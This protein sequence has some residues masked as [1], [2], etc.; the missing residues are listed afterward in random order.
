MEIPK[1]QK[2]QSPRFLEG[3]GEMGHMMRQKDWSLHPLGM[4]KNWPLAL[5]LAIGNLLRTAFPNFI[6]WGQEY[7][8]FYN[9]AYRPSLGDTGK[10]PTILG[11]KFEDAWPELRETMKPIVDEVWRSGRPTWHENQLV[12]ISRNGGIEDVYWTFSYS[13][14]LDENDK[15]AGIMIICMETTQAVQ[16]LKKLEE[17]ED[18]LKFAINAAEL[19]TWDYNPKTDTFRGNNR[20]KDWFGINA[21]HEIELTS[22]MEAI[23]PDDRNRVKLAIE[24]ALTGVN[25]G[26]YDVAYFIKNK[27]TDERK[28]V[29]ALGRAWTD[30]NNEVYR[31]NGTLQDIT[32][33][34]ISVEKLR[35]ANEAVEKERNRFKNIVQKAPVGIALFK[36]EDII[37]QM[38][39]N[40]LLEI[41]DR[42]GHDFVRKALF[43]ALPE[44]ENG[45]RPLFEEVL[46]KRKTVK[47]TEFKVP[48]HRKGVL[49]DAYFD[50]ILQ[51]LNSGG[52]ESDTME[53]MLVANEVTDH[54]IA[55]N[56]LAENENQFRN[57]VQQSP[58]AMAIF[59]SMDL[60]IEM[61][62]QRML[63][64][65]WQRSWEEVVGK[66][67]LD[68][69]PELKN[70]KYIDLL[71]NVILTGKSAHEKNS[72]ALVVV[73]GENHEFYV[74][75]D[76][77]PLKEVDGSVS[78]IMV[79]VVD[80]T[81]QYLA[82][83]KLMNFSKELESQVNERT[84]LLQK[85]NLELALSV[86]KLEQANA[87]L[88]SFAYV[89]SHDLQEPL[90]KIQMYVSRISDQ[91]G[92]NLA[93]NTQRYFDKITSSAKRMRNLIDDL[94]V[95]S[96]KDT[97]KD[98]FTDV[99]LNLILAQ[100]LENLSERIEETNAL[101]DCE[102]LP[103]IFGVPFQ[104]RQVFTNLIGNS[105]KFAKNEARPEITILSTIASKEEIKK[106]GLIKD[107]TYYKIAFKDK[108]IGFP[109][110]MEEKIFEVFYRLHGKGEFEGT[111]I[112][113]SIVKK[114]IENH[115]GKV[116]AESEMGHGTTF[117]LYLPKK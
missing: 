84:E 86:R 4:P 25:D 85:T 24:R 58:I 60:K 87:E 51:P 81:E 13:I 106:I 107:P 115:N 90:R 52:D 40:A 99:D 95:Y 116:I 110:N 27:I 48:M 49:R 64:H 96:R 83:E 53:I 29:R 89:S 59:R 112:G 28:K 42:D 30:E 62:N 100:V 97:S 57:L 43:D 94:L 45:V 74:D 70:Q 11:Q 9:D 3:G 50:F 14:M 103:V 82:R 80:V 98:E 33:Q 22:A 2:Q 69:F 114:I 46:Q 93:G 38:A 10:H 65:F 67:L 75:Y 91:E 20:L 31:F 23:V 26:K 66:K 61:A 35:R 16:N 1:S 8:C 32:E 56:I 54:V 108:G 19:G 15:K 109:K 117:T 101:I 105:L 76:Y 12:P 37:T 104:L 5:R 41:V 18:Q 72:K 6:L 55:R 47:G 78:G 21:S 71:Q 111:G 7:Y 34:A 92:A 73:H 77:R 68:V 88:E 79:T 113:L 102:S 39:N 44:V 63:D 17:S 36:G